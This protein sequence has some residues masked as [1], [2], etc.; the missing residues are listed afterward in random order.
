MADRYTQRID[1]TQLPSSIELID[2]LTKES[3]RDA[4]HIDFIQKNSGIFYVHRQLS[5]LAHSDDSW[6]D[7]YQQLTLD[8]LVLKINSN[9]GELAQFI[10]KNVHHTEIYEDF[11]DSLI[12]KKEIHTSDAIFVFGAA[13]NARIERAI[14]LYKDGVASK[15]IISG[16]SPHYTEDSQSEASRMA[17]F[18]QNNGVP[19]DNIIQE[20]ESVTLHDNVKRSIDLLE[21]MDWRP[22]SLV[23]IATNFVLTRAVMQWYTF[24]PW[25]IQIIPVAA[26]PQSSKFTATGWYRDASTTTLVLH[27]Y[28]KIV[29]GMRI[30][31]LRKDEEIT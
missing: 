28:A 10:Q 8:E 11:Y 27:E 1:S 14:E 12:P 13:T 30:E 4:V 18:A 31:L 26:H 5:Q 7:Q 15:I 17:E 9:H 3:Q 19:R 23:I 20:E 6:I 21:K 16:N 29:L 25:D 24:C 22:A 2:I